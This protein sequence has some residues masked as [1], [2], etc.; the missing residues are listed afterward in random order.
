MNSNDVVLLVDCSREGSWA[1]EPGLGSC[2]R[3]SMFHRGSTVTQRSELVAAKLL[4]E[5]PALAAAHG[6]KINPAKTTRQHACAGYRIVTGI[7]VTTTGIRPTRHS[8]AKS[9]SARRAKFSRHATRVVR[10]KSVPMRLRL[11]RPA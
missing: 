5:I 3:V 11:F 4:A 2:R 9:G 1:E 6:F 10:S 8:N 7:A